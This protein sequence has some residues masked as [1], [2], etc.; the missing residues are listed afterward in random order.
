MR[1]EEVRE[2]FSVCGRRDSVA[3][4]GSVQPR[5]VGKCRPT[6]GP[7]AGSPPSAAPLNS[8]F[9]LFLTFCGHQASAPQQSQLE[10]ENT[11][12]TRRINNNGNL[13]LC[14]KY[15]RC[16]SPI[17]GIKLPPINRSNLRLNITNTR[18]ANCSFKSEESDW[19]KTC[20]DKNEVSESYTFLGNA[21]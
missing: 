15:R 11:V 16:N 5:M 14:W 7:S 21:D 10:F 17:S 20:P 9:N 6:L 19:V 3:R 18:A 2:R 13:N 12:E 1:E 8:C 4:E